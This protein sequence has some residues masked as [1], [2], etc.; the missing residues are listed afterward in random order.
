[1]KRELD[2]HIVNVPEYEKESEKLVSDCCGEEI[3]EVAEIGEEIEC[4]YCKGA[5][6]AE[7]IKKWEI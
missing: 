1:M 6:K 4:P 7:S 5:C 3:K 2:K